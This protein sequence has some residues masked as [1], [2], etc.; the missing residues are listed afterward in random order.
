MRNII[1][2]S[3]LQ[4]TMDDLGW[5]NG[6]DGRQSMEPA[7]TGITRRH[8][9]E[10]YE[11]VNEIG[12][13]L[14]M[15]IN[16]AFVM[17]EW[18]PDNR[19]KTIPALSPH[20][21]NWNNSLHFDKK[22]AARCVD[23]INSAEYIDFAVHGLHHTYYVHGGQYNNTDYYYTENNRVIAA[24]ES[25]IR[26]RLDAYFDLIEYHGF[27]KTI[28]SFIPPTFTYQP[29]HLT[30]I[31]KDYGI[32][33]A[34]TTFKNIGHEDFSG[35]VVVDNGIPIVDRNN[36]LIPWNVMEAELDDLPTVSGIFGCH[37]ANVCHK[38]PKE[39]LSLVDS[40]VNYFER[41]KNTYGIILS[42]DIAFCSTQ[43]L[44]KK[45]SKLSFDSGKCIIDTSDVP[46][47]DGLGTSFY[48]STDK[49]LSEWTGCDV[50]IYERIGDFI[51]YEVT[52]R[53]TVLTLA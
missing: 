10:D 48:V 26:M 4:I 21:I 5:F 8:V 41:C 47:A 36:N 19:L 28:N 20:G 42:R 31:L 40:W 17:A 33:Y 52:P 34:S 37:W 30:K 35:G 32:L 3:P 43:M 7:R 13:R 24:P 50:K 18:D 25:E 29:N 15:R 38:D 6:T 46:T 45:Y 39:N 23:V 53:S 44:Y 22:E 51:N 27:K 2:P 11:V 9:A 12:R 14:G 1:I 49:P 16:C